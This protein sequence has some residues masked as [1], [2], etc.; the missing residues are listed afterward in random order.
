VQTL[1]AALAETE[2]ALA[3]APRVGKVA[4]PVERAIGL[5]RFQIRPRDG[6]YLEAAL[7]PAVPQIPV[8]PMLPAFAE[9][10]AGP[11]VR[12]LMDALE[13]LQVALVW[14]ADCAEFTDANLNSAQFLRAGAQVQ[15]AAD[16]LV[17]LARH[18]AL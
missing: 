14:E 18:G 4:E 15:I 3:G 12:A 7:S 13:A 10:P 17:E 2:R 1:E 16:A 11:A 5:A 8:G 6:P 9:V